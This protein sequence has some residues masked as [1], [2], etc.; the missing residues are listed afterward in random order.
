MANTIQIS[1]DTSG[2]VRGV[3]Q[4]DNAMRGL[5]RNIQA[6]TAPGMFDGLGGGFAK[7][8][9]G[10][11]IMAALAAG[12]RKFYSAM[13]A[14]GTLVDLSAQ[15]GLAVD[16]LMVLQLAF[17]QAGMS[18]GDVQ[19][20]IAKLQKSVAEAANGNADAAAKF[21]T[22]GIAI[23]DIQALSADAQLSAIGDA[24]SKIENPAQRSAI[25]MEIFGKSG[26]KLLSV[27]S[28]G[29]F[30]ATA[31]ASIE[32]IFQKAGLT[33]QQAQPSVALLQST[34]SS[35][36]NGSAQSAQKLNTLGLSFQNLNKLSASEQL[37]S[38][39]S[40]IS[41]IQNPAERSAAATKILGE[42]GE[43]L[44]SAFSSGGLQDVQKNIGNQA[45]L[46][47]QNAGIFDR[48]TDVLNTAGSKIQGFFVG[49][50]SQIMPPLISVVDKINSIDLSGIGKA[51]GSGIADALV[52]LQNFDSVGVILLDSL[53]LAFATAA[54]FFWTQM[55]TSIFK[56]G[57]YLTQAFNVA[58]AF[59]KG[60]VSAAAPEIYATIKNALQSAGAFL[61][62][63]WSDIF[64]KVSIP[65]KLA[66][67]TG[68]NFLNETFQKTIPS[69][70]SALK[71]AFAQAIN[72]LGTELSVAFA[73]TAAAFKSMLPGGGNMDQEANK[74]E[75][76]ARA[77]PALIDIGKLEADKRAIESKP[78]KPIWDTTQ[79]MEDFKSL[80]YKTAKPL[81]DTDG[82]KKN[83]SSGYDKLKAL[84]EEATASAR[85]KYATPAPP[86][87][88][89]DFIPKTD[90]KPVGSIVS[91]LAKI[92]G[93]ITGPRTSGIDIARSQLQAQQQ[94]AQ[95]TAKL[96]EKMNKP[97]SSATSAVVYQ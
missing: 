16:K 50:A 62:S 26:A 8:L 43:K 70:Y 85:E 87:P 38:V 63:A 95:N 19:P 79:L 83:V 71:I 46:M 84:K 17:E 94:T 29:V 4:A 51:L 2:F 3:Q 96:V 44:L 97:T 77:K 74:A 80:D 78:I 47:V 10:V 59:F 22:M 65:L 1:A 40:A 81:F 34:I 82:L 37:A 93:D 24:I 60:D 33:A 13:E 48:A 55:T 42:N 9:G 72:F 11:S 49:M 32:D 27:F 76:Q 35:A 15:T 54:N 30:D 45:Q 58:V 91:S 12:V 53:K 64:P 7:L 90:T 66:F 68:I 14:G 23:K 52:L 75:A 6:A 36:A 61:T 28:S 39:A 56:I 69:I 67:A 57:D 73:R 18:A 41:K 5:G 25:A 89:A 21:S 31:F 88:G 92:G 86:P 20:V